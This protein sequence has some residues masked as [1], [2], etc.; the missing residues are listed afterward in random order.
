MTTEDLN[1]QLVALEPNGCR[2]EVGNTVLTLLDLRN[3]SLLGPET[4]PQIKTSCPTVW[5]LLD[6][7]TDPEKL[8]QIPHEGTVVT[9]SETGNRDS[10]AIRYLVQYGFSNLIGLRFGMRRWLKL[11]YPTVTLEHSE[12]VQ[13]TQ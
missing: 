3:N 13:T 1:D 7:L 8:S 5:I 9:I 10:F 11:Q 12:Q 2:D 6:D 4:I